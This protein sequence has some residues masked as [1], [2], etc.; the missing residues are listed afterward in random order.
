MCDVSKLLDDLSLSL[1][2][3][4]E[5]YNIS[6]GLDLVQKMLLYVVQKHSTYIHGSGTCVCA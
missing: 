6:G 3:L 1:L 5:G 2:D 4:N